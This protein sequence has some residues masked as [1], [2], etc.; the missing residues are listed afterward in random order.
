MNRLRA[1]MDASG[2]FTNFATLYLQTHKVDSDFE[3]TPQILARLVG[4]P[5]DAAAP[6]GPVSPEKQKERTLA[7]L[8]SLLLGMTRERARVFVV[9]DIH[10]ADPGT[11]ETLPYLVRNLRSDAVVRL[12]TYRSDELHRRHPLLPWLAEIERTGRVQRIDVARLEREYYE[13]NQ[14]QKCTPPCPVVHRGSIQ[15]VE[16]QVNNDAGDRYVQPDRKCHPRHAAMSDESAGEREIQARQDHRHGVGVPR[17]VDLQHQRIAGGLELAGHL[18]LEGRETAHVAAE[19]WSAVARRHRQ[20]LGD[21][22]I[23]SIAVSRQL[24]LVTRNK[25]DFE[26]LS[27]ASG[28]ESSKTRIRGHH[29]PGKS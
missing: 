29:T 19:I 1:V 13:R 5:Q 21:V 18:E 9:E 17:V 6:P 15:P 26:R 16:H 10:W 22:L 7:T 4:L 12:V 2:S 24:P 27:K 11:R 28:I 20:Q 23:A 25:R 14:Q 8:V 3:V